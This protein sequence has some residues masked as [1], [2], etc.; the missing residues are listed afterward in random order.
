MPEIITEI[1]E[2]L[3]ETEQDLEDLGDPMPSSK[4]EKLHMVWAMIYEFV[5]GYKNQISGKFDA[6][7]KVVMGG[8][9]ANALSGG[10]RIKM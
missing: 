8:P 9:G 5:Q 10:A 6:K 7:R 1:R 3:K 4:G 2:K